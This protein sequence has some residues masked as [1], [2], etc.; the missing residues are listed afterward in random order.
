MKILREDDASPAK[1][2]IVVSQYFG[3]VYYKNKSSLVFC[4]EPEQVV[5]CA[6]L[7]RL[8]LKDIG[9]LKLTK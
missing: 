1:D 9:A 7:L 6:K 3:M 8:F 2:F 5:R 4:T